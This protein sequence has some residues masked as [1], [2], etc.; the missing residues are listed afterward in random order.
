MLSL[1]EDLPI[2]VVIVDTDDH[3][4]EFLPAL[5]DLITE[6]LVIIDDVQ[7]VKYVGRTSSQDE[8]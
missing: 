1:S 7:V 8:S 2:T 3:I 4:N 6:G 5:D